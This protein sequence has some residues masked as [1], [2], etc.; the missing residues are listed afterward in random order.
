MDGPGIFQNPEEICEPKIS[1][2]KRHFPDLTWDCQGASYLVGGFNP[3]E[4]YLSNWIIFPGKGENKK[5]LKPPPSYG[6]FP[7]LGSHIF[8]ERCADQRLGSKWVISPSVL[9]NVA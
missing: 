7:I 8:T 2:K 6:K 5:K 1:V 9:K 4:K 3:F